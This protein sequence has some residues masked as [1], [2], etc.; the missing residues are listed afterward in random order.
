MGQPGALFINDVDSPGQPPESS[1]AGASHARGCL[2]STGLNPGEH[3]PFC[4][5]RFCYIGSTLLRRPGY[6]FPSSSSYQLFETNTFYHCSSSLR[7]Q[8]QAPWPE[9]LI[10]FRVLRLLKS[11][12]FMKYFSK[13]V[14]S[15]LNKDLRLYLTE[16]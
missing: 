12:E 10:A 5:R 1:N 15:F 16:P 14:C 8:N 6:Y 3:M 13:V 2:S 9:S 11:S 7:W 4:K